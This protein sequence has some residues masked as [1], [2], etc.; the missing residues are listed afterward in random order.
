MDTRV[1]GIIAPLVV[2]ILVI[3]SPLRLTLYITADG[4]ID[5]YSIFL[6]WSAMF[7]SSGF[8]YFINEPLVAFGYFL[9]CGPRFILPIQLLRFYRNKTS[10]R[11]VIVSSFIGEILPILF[12]FTVPLHFHAYVGPMPL[13]IFAAAIFLLI[14]QPCSP[15]TPWNNY[16]QTLE[17]I[18]S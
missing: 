17:E 5:I 10:F 18:Y 12:I 16:E 8:S 13:Y 14:K 6:F 15:Q 7:D 3:F 2:G 9:F 4:E 11:M 1:I